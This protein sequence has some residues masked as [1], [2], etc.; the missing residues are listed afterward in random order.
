MSSHA[1]HEQDVLTLTPVGA[2][3][4][5]AQSVSM[6]IVTPPH[7]SLCPPMYCFRR[8]CDAQLDELTHDMTLVRWLPS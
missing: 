2:T 5:L 8:W 1:L 4:P 6:F 7:V 3:G